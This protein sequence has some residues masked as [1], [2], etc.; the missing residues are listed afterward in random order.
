M[1]LD[2]S[3]LAG[4][5]DSVRLTVI[6]VASRTPSESGV[7]EI[8]TSELARWLGLSA[9]YVASV[10]IPALRRS[11]LVSVETK[12]GEFG[13]DECLKCR[14]LP[15][16]AAQDV[17]GHPL[18]LAKKEYS[19]FLRLL[20][21]VMAPG[22]THR[23]GSVTPAGL[24]GTRTGRGA[25]TDRLA[26]LLLV[27]E[28]RESGQVRLCGG[29][30]DTRRGRAAATVARLMGCSASAG[31]RVLERLEDQELVLRRR[32]KT[33]SGLRSR[34]RLMVP[35][36]AAAH[37]RTV[38]DDVQEDLA[39]A[40]EAEISDPDVAAGPVEAPE[41]DTESKVSGLLGT[42]GAAVAEPDVA[43]TLHTDHSSV[44]TQAVRPQ[45][46]GRFSGEG[47]GTAGRRP[48]HACAGEEQAVDSETNV[49]GSWSSVAAGGPLRGEQPKESPVNERF[50]QRVA[51]AGAGERPKG[52]GW[53]KTRQQRRWGL[54]DDLRLRVAL[55]PVTW[56][57]ERLSRWQQDQVEAAAK[58][59]LARLDALLMQQGAAPR[60]LA[61]RL[62]D[63]LE[64]TGGEA[65]IGDPY[66][67]LIRRGLPQRRACPDLRCDDGTRLD[68]R[69]ECE[70]CRNVL[71]LR[72]GMRARAA[73]DIERR[74]PGLGDAE[75]HRA[76]EARLRQLA[77]IEAE[78]YVWRREQARAE[79]VRRDAARAAA[80]DRAER[81]RLASAAAD[82]VRQ[83]LACE[84]CGQQQAGGLC[85]TCD[86]CRQ[87]ETLISQ[88]GLL[89]ATWSADL[90][91][92]ASVAAVAATVRTAIGHSVTAAWQ[93][94]LEM[95]DTTGVAALEASPE[96]ARDAYAFAA[97]QTT[98]QALQEH[99]DTAL[100]ML[101]QTQ[102]AEAEAQRAYKTEQNRR[103]YRYNPHGADAVAAATK[104]A[105]TAR[106]R[107]AEYLLATRLEQLSEQANARTERPASWTDR[108]PELT[109]RPLDGDATGMVIA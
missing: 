56:L 49:A 94:F 35:A 87:T 98:Q 9:S 90:T 70:N 17:V 54:P 84:D 78:D 71:H 14:V 18:N 7:V 51:G 11:A 40:P 57:W 63:R 30:V 79:H 67:W 81:E 38:A 100:A 6:V 3:G 8:R 65:L 15:L 88:A 97:L 60:L 23:D 34:S 106:E 103:W 64:E 27:L 22:W 73:A 72:R 2:A 19:T 52:T 16:W 33:G 28:A 68:T 95:T 21:A 69:T 39:E 74:Q 36:V 85:E 93:E 109:A 75:R 45:L 99:H 80:A 5:P 24:I 83:A 4:A 82:A 55:G 61:E 50:G 96:A 48:E 66:A 12:E 26:L 31:E 53:E 59:E 37:G 86:H 10:V 41:A 13:Q 102:E 105:D 62:T 108:L 1:L 92:P 104:A 58:T 46:S 44:V 29:T 77:A 107:V 43:A 20:E 25:A 47:R 42:D 89:V 91:D 101:S 32:L 76:V